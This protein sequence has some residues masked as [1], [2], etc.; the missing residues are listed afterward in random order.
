VGAAGSQAAL[1]TASDPGDDFRGLGKGGQGGKQ[2]PFSLMKILGVATTWW[3][4]SPV[5]IRAF[6]QVPCIISELDPSVP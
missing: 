1:I 5:T 6:Q 3:P 4:S 2:E